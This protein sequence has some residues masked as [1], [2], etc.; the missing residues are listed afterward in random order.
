MGIQ[1]WNCV[2]KQYDHKVNI[3]SVT[4]VY[5]SSTRIYKIEYPYIDD[6]IPADIR[7]NTSRYTI[8]YPYIDDRIPVYNDRVPVYR[9]SRTSIYIND[10]TY[11]QYMIK[12]PY[13]YDRVPVYWQS[14]PR[15]Y[16]YIIK[17]YA[18]LIINKTFV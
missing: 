7:S 17:T 6:R 8:E 12:Y 10:Y 15:V 16:I 11:L 4:T 1:Q 3:Y 5:S 2:G 13:I 9:Q 14:S 18:I